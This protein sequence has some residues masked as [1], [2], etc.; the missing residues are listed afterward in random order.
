VDLQGDIVLVNRINY[1][2]RLK[3]AGFQPIAPNAIV[4]VKVQQQVLVFLLCPAMSGSQIRFPLNRLACG[5]RLGQT[6]ARQRPE[7]RQ[8]ECKRGGTG[9]GNLHDQSWRGAAPLT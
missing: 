4:A 9:D 8:N 5:R 6:V 2:W 3:R 7:T 1:L